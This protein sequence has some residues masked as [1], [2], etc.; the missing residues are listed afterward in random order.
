MSWIAPF[1][2]IGLLS[3]LPMSQFS[4]EPDS[5]PKIDDLNLVPEFHQIMNPKVDPLLLERP[6]NENVTVV[7]ELIGEAAIY[8]DELAKKD[9]LIDTFYEELVQASMPASK[10][11]E[12]SKLTFVSYIR[13]PHEAVPLVISEGLEQLKAD[14]MQELG[15]Q[16]EGVKVA[17]ID[18]GFDLNNPEIRDNIVDWRSFTRSGNIAQ[19]TRHGTG[20]AEIVIDVAPKA[21]LLLYNVDTP[22]E[23]RMAVD[24]AIRAGAQILSISLAWFNAGP[25]DGTS[26]VSTV[27]DG[28]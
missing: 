5:N 1:V 27:L 18:D 4:L 26:S 19:T 28:L 2:I 11:E 13:Y 20:V 22:L 6:P 15:F 25:Y 12:I 14:A 3:F 23:L 10:I 7:L 8:L 17:V 21:S 16:G 9:V 24:H